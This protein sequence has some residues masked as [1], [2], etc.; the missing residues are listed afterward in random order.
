MPV[1]QRHYSAADSVSTEDR[2]GRVILFSAFAKTM[3]YMC[4]KSYGTEFTPYVC[5]VISYPAIFLVNNMHVQGASDTSRSVSFA[6]G[7]GLKRGETLQAL[8]QHI[9]PTCIHRRHPHP[10]Y[11]NALWDSFFVFNYSVFVG[12]RKEIR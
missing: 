7:N 10:V 2:T 12:L 5:N 11:A 6:S 9:L 1:L 4:I 3:C 8:R